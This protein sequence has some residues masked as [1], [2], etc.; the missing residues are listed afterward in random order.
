MVAHVA[1]AAPRG[2]EGVRVEIEVRRRGAPESRCVLVG[3]PDAAVKESRERVESAIR[4][5]GY[6]YPGGRLTVNLAPADLR[7]EGPAYDLPIALGIL[8]AGGV[9]GAARL[10]GVAAVGELALD[11]RVRPVKGVLA[12]AA[13]CRAHGLRRL[14][15]PAGNAR[16]AAVV[17]GLDVL[18]VRTLADAVRLLNGADPAVPVRVNLHELFSEMNVYDADFAEV[19]GQEHVKRALLIAAAG[20]HNVLMIGPPGTGKTM[21][22]R[23]LPTLLPPLTL[24]ES[25]ETTKIHSVAGALPPGQA[26]V[27]T[28]PFRAPHHT[29]SEPA[30]VGGGTMPKPGEVSLA[31]HGVLFLDELPEFNRRTLELLRQPLED[32]TVT[33]GR[34]AASLAFPARIM[35]VAAMNPC[36]CGY[37][38]DARRPCTCTPRQAQGYM[39]KVSGPLLDR[40]DLHVETPSVPSEAILGRSEGTSSAAMRSQ[41][42]R[43]RERQRAR[44]AESGRSDL[45][46]A[47]D[48]SPGRSDLQVAMG[49]EAAGAA[50]W[51]GPTGSGA[52]ADT[53]LRPPLLN[54]R[55]T[56]RHL[57]KWCTPDA[58]GDALLRQALD[59]LGF[60]A[61]AVTRVLKVARTIAD[62]EGQDRIAAAHL[63]EAIQYRTLDRAP[64]K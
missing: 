23:R 22:A 53:H 9:V 40:I 7:K 47:T 38:M 59:E 48:A 63:A 42:M 51:R 36:P 26:L 31:H 30:L 58:E 16:E 27:V 11:G 19:R 24:S 5:S 1:S 61:R 2:I 15:A 43:A 57:R 17:E 29:V 50:P 28:R 33:I 41:V 35:L 37:A 60:S 20:G 4:A 25:L 64:A 39:A 14:L 55:L 18:P 3:L 49:A 54:A 56:S 46:V 8:G 12:L 52:A 32:G 13:A 21:L 45:Q 44:A 62:L 34:A 10:E 6:R